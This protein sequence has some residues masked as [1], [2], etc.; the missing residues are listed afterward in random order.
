MVPRHGHGF[1]LKCKART[2][3]LVLKI[4]NNGNRHSYITYVTSQKQSQK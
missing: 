1:D 2:R 3:Y 4:D